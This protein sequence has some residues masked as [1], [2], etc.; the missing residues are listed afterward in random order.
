MLSGLV[1]SLWSS[2]TNTPGGGG[3]DGEEGNMIQYL[4]PLRGAF[5]ADVALGSLWLFNSQHVEWKEDSG[6]YVQCA[7]ASLWPNDEPP[8]IWPLIAKER[9]QIWSKAGRWPV[10]RVW[11]RRVRDV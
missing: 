5:Q 7:A 1:T 3:R 9:K 11:G 6:S 10:I 2:E 8:V 4:L